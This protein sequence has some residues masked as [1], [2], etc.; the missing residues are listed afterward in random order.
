MESWVI[1]GIIASFVW[2]GY[3]VLLKKATSERY[4]ALTSSM[5]FFV[6]SLGILA[7]SLGGLLLGSNDKSYF[8]QGMGIAFASGLLW[9]IGM[10]CVIFT[11]SSANTMV[12][13]LTPLYNTNTLVAVF[14]GILLLHEVPG[15][16]IAIIVGAVLVV[17]G[18]ILVTREVAIGTS[19]DSEVSPESPVKKQTLRRLF[20][21]EN[22][23]TW[24]MIAS[25]VWGIYAI[26]LKVATSPQYYDID[27]FSAFFAMSLGILATSSS[28]LVIAGKGRRGFPRIKSKGGL[29][30][31]F[32]G[33]LWS[34]GMISIIYA[35]SKWG[36]S[37]APLVPLY[38]T[39]TLVA[40]LLGI[41][42]L[43]EVPKRRLSII[44]TILGAV[45]IVIGGSIVTM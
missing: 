33:I 30:A 28:I 10:G 36:A 34:I 25:L 7:I 41:I 19:S 16:R 31:L 13:R 39:N 38:N 3:I 9:G 42:L 27:P 17:L 6:M 26:L 43:G 12:S 24:G 4:Y 37:V 21:P 40:V 22:W 11:L 35:F 18:G 14:L 45:L 29:A 23:I 8:Q 44:L 15:Q 1:C 20:A 2:G 5:A 32:S